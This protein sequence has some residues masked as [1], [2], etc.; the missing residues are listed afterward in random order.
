VVPEYLWRN[1]QEN[2][3]LA[4]G[5][6]PVSPQSSDVNLT[7]NPEILAEA[8][9]DKNA[10]HVNQNTKALVCDLE[11]HKGM[12]GLARIKISSYQVIR[13]KRLSTHVEVSR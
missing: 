9:A 11:G 3:I 7:N 13:V 2:R 10:S 1:E 6:A 4:L 8:V 5:L 12:F